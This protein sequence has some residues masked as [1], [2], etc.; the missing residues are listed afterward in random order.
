MRRAFVQNWMLLV[1]ALVFTVTIPVTSNGQGRGGGAPRGGGLRAGTIEKVESG[2]R[3]ITVYLPPSYGSDTGRQFPVIYFLNDSDEGSD[4]AVEAIKSSADRLAGV[5]GFS[6]PIV[7]IASAPATADLQRQP[8]DLVAYIDSHYRTFK[9]RISRGLAGRFR[10]G[11]A[12]F[13]VAMNRPDVFSSLYL[14]NASG[15]DMASLVEANE[16]NLM[17]LY[18]ISIDIGTKAPSLA[19]NQQLH[20]AL[21]RL[22]IPHKYEEYDGGS[23]NQP[24]ERFEANLLPFFSKSL[25]APANPTSPGVK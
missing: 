18:G 21:M 15:G 16:A 1:V 8:D 22:H 17:K 13:R 4:A 9:A 6:E 12:A 24:G 3:N 10:G 23:P 11:D 25:A 19:A 2:G 14:L 20:Q 5:Q 7:V